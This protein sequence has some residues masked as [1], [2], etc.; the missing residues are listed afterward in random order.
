[1]IIVAPR[2]VKLLSIVIDAY[3]ITIWP[4][5]LTSAPLSESGENHERIHLRQQTELLVLGFYVL[6]VYD[7]IVGKMQGMSGPDAY[8]AIRFEKEAYE[9][10][11]DPSYL[12]YRPFWAWREYNQG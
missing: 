9:N 8:M 1:M 5:M 11:D 12:A 6:Y 2:L 3:A 7:F 10:E 4:I